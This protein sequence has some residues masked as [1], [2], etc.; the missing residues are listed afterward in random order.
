M[1][2]T[3]QRIDLETMNEIDKLREH[4]AKK[5]LKL[6]RTELLRE[7]IHMIRDEE[8]KYVRKFVKSHTR[9]KGLPPGRKKFLETKPFKFDKKT[10]ATEEVDFTL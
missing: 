6:K 3:T 10:N 8:P 1:D 4:L 2:Y 5:G 9:V 7:M